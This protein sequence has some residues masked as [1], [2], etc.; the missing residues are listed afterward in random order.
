MHKLLYLLGQYFYNSA[1]LTLFFVLLCCTLLLIAFRYPILAPATYFILSITNPQAQ[2][3]ILNAMQPVQISALVSIIVFFVH[4]QKAQFKFDSNLAF[5]LIFFLA[6]VLSYVDAQDSSLAEKRFYEFIKITVMTVLTMQ[7]VGT[8]KDYSILFFATL[9]AFLYKIV[10]NLA[11]T[12]TIGRWGYVRGSGGWI[13]D[14][15]DWAL[16]LVMV[17]PLFYAA[18]RIANSK[19]MKAFHL[20]S[21]LG[22]ILVLSLTFSR[23]GFLGFGVSFAFLFLLEQKKK[24]ILILL[25]VLSPLVAYYMPSHTITEFTSIFEEAKKTDEALSGELKDEEYSGVQRMW[26][27]KLAYRIMN[28]N[29]LTGVGC[30]NFTQVK[31]LYDPDATP[32]VAHSTWFQ[33]GAEAGYLGLASFLAMI[34]S[35]MFLALRAYRTGRKLG[36]DWLAYNGA[37]IFCALLAYCVSASF[38]SREY[39]DFLYLLLVFSSS[40]FALAKAEKMKAKA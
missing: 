38:V 5:I 9:L 6:S 29:P 28:D 1:T 8:R 26:E 23:G 21:L 17:F 30:G 20:L 27:W 10:N 2:S 25:L 3:A 40:L 33:V 14:S 22:G 16:A 11:D 19:K 18:F 15:N 7:M 37:G 13:G 36:D 35:G 24:Q 32:I 39:S 12:Q 31:M 4:I 34:L